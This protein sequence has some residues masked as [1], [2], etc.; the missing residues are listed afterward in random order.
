[1]LCAE[2]GN[3][4]AKVYRAA[5]SATI[6]GNRKGEPMLPDTFE[7]RT[8]PAVFSAVMLSLLLGLRRQ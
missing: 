2:L 8:K 7:L 3:D 6:F 4:G 5:L 1:M